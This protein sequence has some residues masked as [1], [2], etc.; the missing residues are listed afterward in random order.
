MLVLGIDPG[1]ATTGYGFVREE[2]DG[3]VIAVAYG[4]VSTPAKTP[5]PKR[6]QQLYRE[7]T[8]LIA[9]YK[10]DAAAIEE[11]F[12]GK[13]VTAAIHVAQG[14][15]VALLALADANL[16]I[17]EYKPA[18]IKQAIAGYGNAAKPQ[19]QEMVKTLLNLETIPK[20]DD[21]ADALAI[22]LT[23]LQSSRW[24]RLVDEGEG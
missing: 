6:L 8:H 22:A 19:M 20:P 23:A 14:R 4:V 21:A 10:P 13:N 17:H 2:E 11:M 15:G 9:T 1:T 16:R 3:Q 24:E 5:M 12:F 7:L 18:S